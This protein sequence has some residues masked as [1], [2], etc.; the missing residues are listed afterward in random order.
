MKLTDGRWYPLLL[1]RDALGRFAWLRQQ[2]GPKPR[3]VRRSRRPRARLDAV[4][5]VLF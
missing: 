3:P 4:Q 1:L 2:P 5:L